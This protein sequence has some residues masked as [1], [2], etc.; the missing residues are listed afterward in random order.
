[1][2]D[3]ETDGFLTDDS[4]T[5]DSTTDDSTTDDSMSDDSV[6]TRPVTGCT[7]GCDPGIGGTVGVRSETG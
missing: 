7:I 3:F 6:G 1:M 2:D 4:T 5:D